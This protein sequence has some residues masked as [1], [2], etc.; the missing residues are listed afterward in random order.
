MAAAAD[1]GENERGKGMRRADLPSTA[2]KT[3]DTR[4][5]YHIG[6]SALIDRHRLTKFPISGH[7]NILFWLRPTFHPSSA[8]NPL[9]LSLTALRRQFL[10][11]GRTFDFF[12][13]SVHTKLS[14]TTKPS[15]VVLYRRL[16]FPSLSP[17]VDPPPLLQHGSQELNAELYDFIALALRAYITPWWSKIT[18]YDRE[19]VPHVAYIIGVVTRSLETRLLAADIPEL[20]FRAVPTLLSQHFADYRAASAKVGTSYALGG[21]ATL[22]HLFH[23]LQGHMAIDAEGHIDP[24]YIRHTLDLILQA[25]L[26]PDDYNSDAERAIIREVIVKVL[27][28]DVVPLLVQ[29]WFIH[30]QLLDIVR[31]S[32]EKSASPVKVCM[33]SDRTSRNEC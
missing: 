11:V 28:G 32:L 25:C 31:P 12:M 10:V 4:H 18:R 3:N 1:E 26:P 29:P 14:T 17:S 7:F 6:T 20:L 16:L 2:T 19:F 13:S 15:N 9:S 27:L 33:R 23:Q 8:H 22:P 24:E 5:E 30:K 21:A